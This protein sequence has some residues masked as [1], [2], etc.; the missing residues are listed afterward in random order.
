MSTSRTSIRWRIAQAAEHR[1]WRNYLSGKDVDDYLAWKR[2]YWHGFLKTLD[3]SADALDRPVLDAGCGPAGLFTILSGDVTAL[4]PLLD[5]YGALDVFDRSMHPDVRFV[6]GSLEDLNDKDRYATIACLNAINHVADLGEA[7][8][9]LVAAL[10]P[11][12]RLL[13]STDAHRH[14]WLKPLFRAVPADVLHPHQHDR[15]DY[16]AMLEQRGLVIETEVVMKREAIFEYVVWC[17]A[18]RS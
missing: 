6:T 7:L 3:L 12:G 11:G 15:A 1:W 14:G 18:P 10:A 17:C 16:R 13:L 4:D 9:R 8:D 5:R 2:G